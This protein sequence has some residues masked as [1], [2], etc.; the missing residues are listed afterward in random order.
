[1]RKL[2]IFILVFLGGTSAWAMK[3]AGEVAQGNRLYRQ[4]KYAQALVQYE[5]A[6]AKNSS[7]ARI[8]FDLGSAAYKTGDYDR[9]VQYLQ[10]SLLTDDEAFKSNIHYNLGDAFYK[11]GISRE[12]MNVDDAIKHLKSSLESFEKACAIDLKNTDAANNH[13]FVKKELDR[14]QLKKQQ[15]QQKNQPQDTKKDKNQDNN[16]DQKQDQPSENQDQKKEDQPQS[17]KSDQ[18]PENSKGQQQG[19]SKD[20]N[21][22]DARQQKDLGNDHKPGD[23]AHDKSST[24]GQEAQEQILSRSEAQAMVDDFER[25]ELPKGLL[26]FVPKQGQERPVEKDW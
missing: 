10:K 14:L 26:N 5:K 17:D 23:Q 1:M 19:D 16:Q 3:G 9:A 22:D 8:A 18:Q 13:E 2:I 6:D 21:P 11:K 24:S 25:N 20:Q 12:N 7:D 15:K 4:G